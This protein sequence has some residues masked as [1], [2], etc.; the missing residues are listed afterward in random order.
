MEDTLSAKAYL[1]AAS[2]TTYLGFSSYALA[3]NERIVADPLITS[4]AQ[5]YGVT[6]K[7][8]ARRMAQLGKISELEQWLQTE[9]P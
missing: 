8:A 7:E 5:D 9:N 3:Q 6:P 4:Y 2:L 1:L